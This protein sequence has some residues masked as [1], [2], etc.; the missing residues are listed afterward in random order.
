MAGWIVKVIV[1]AAALWVAVRVVPEISFPAARHF[2]GEDWWKLALVALIFGLINAYVKPIV[3]L[4]SLPA[5]I[6]TLGL[7]SLVINAAMLLVLAYAS[8]P[9]KLGLEI[10]GFPPTLSVTTIG[11][12]VLG[13]IIISVVSTALGLALKD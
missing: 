13:S 10:G 11:A 3:R 12:A 9:F 7:F 6:A 1:N 5:R 8:S 4:F 2:P